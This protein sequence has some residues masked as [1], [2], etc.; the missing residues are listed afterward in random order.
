MFRVNG[1]NWIEGHVDFRRIDP[2]LAE[3]RGHPA[4]ALRLRSKLRAANGLRGTVG[5]SVARQNSIKERA[6]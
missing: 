3:S 1:K 2:I 4:K 5:A 6:A